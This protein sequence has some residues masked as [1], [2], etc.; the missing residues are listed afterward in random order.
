ML[1]VPSLLTGKKLYKRSS[2][3]IPSLVVWGAILWRVD[4]SS[5]YTD[6]RLVRHS[7]WL[8]S[9]V[10]TGDVLHAYQMGVDG[11][12]KPFFT[13]AGK[14]TLS[15]AGKGVP[16]ITSFNGQPGTGIVSNF[17]ILHVRQYR[18]HAIIGM[19]SR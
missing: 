6:R 9:Y 10:P 3:P 5:R 16:T 12:G 4:I 13:L 19:D 8:K 7:D 1:I 2:T 14:S 18:T 11:S 15:F 17:F